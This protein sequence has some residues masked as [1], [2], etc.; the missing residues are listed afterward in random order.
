[1]EDL[2][3]IAKELYEAYQASGGNW[4]LFLPFVPL[5]LVQLYKAPFLQNLIASKWPGAAWDALPKYVQWPLAFLV[6][7]LPVLGAQMLGGAAF[8]TAAMLAAGAGL[9]AVFGFKPLQMLATPT[10]GRAGSYL[11]DPATSKLLRA[12]SLVV[13]LD[14]KM[15]AEYKAKREAQ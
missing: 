5:A 15:V 6:G 14:M 4:L 1:M 12:T 7:S 8:A 9:A 3:V 13:P 11:P 10:L 2:Q